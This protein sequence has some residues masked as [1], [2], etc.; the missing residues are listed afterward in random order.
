MEPFGQFIAPSSRQEME[1]AG[2]EFGGAIS[3]SKHFKDCLAYPYWQAL[4]EMAA[5]GG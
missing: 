5:R 2:T 1:Q 3:A 4:E